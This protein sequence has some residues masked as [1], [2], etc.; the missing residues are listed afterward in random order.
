LRS[1]R[2][3]SAAKVRT[4]AAEIPLSSRALA[5]LAREVLAKGRRFRFKALGYS[6][7]PF[8]RNGDI[9]TVSPPPAR[10]L[11][12]GDVAAVVQP[13]S[14]KLVIHRVTRVTPFQA[15]V[16][17]DNT[18]GDG[19]PIPRSHIL[20]RVTLVERKGRPVSFGLG[21]G[22]VA[23]LRLVRLRHRSWLRPLLRIVRPVLK[24]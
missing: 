5:E 4:R 14:G 20:G 3:E 13:E 15:I 18:P 19:E 7:H 10:G 1:A 24:P 16:R 2:A 21:P 23:L 12:A 8:I 6:M 9:L 11:A 17:G 22:R